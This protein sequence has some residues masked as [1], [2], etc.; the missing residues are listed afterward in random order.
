MI[1]W[2]DATRDY[3]N[4]GFVLQALNHNTARVLLIVNDAP[5]LELLALQ[6][7][8]Y[9]YWGYTLHIDE[10]T[11]LRPRLK[12]NDEREDGSEP[13]PEQQTVSKS[14]TIGMEVA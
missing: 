10:A 11:V 5:A 3:K 2:P 4:V 6:H 14:D 12:A 1:G 13:N 7:G 8:A 9:M